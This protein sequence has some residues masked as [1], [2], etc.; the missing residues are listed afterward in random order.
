VPGR[1]AWKELKAAGHEIGAAGAGADERLFP[2][3]AEDND[4]SV[5]CWLGY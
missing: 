4:A 1:A 3:K 5:F 2:L